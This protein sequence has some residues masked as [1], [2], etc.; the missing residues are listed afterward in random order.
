MRFLKNKKILTIIGIIL[1]I[2]VCFGIDFLI[3]NFTNDEVWTGESDIIEGD[4]D[5]EKS[6]ENSEGDSGIENDL[7]DDVSDSENLD[8]SSSSESSGNSEGSGES[9]N[10]KGENGE[11]SMSNDNTIYV[12]VTGEVN[13]QGVVILKEGSRITDAINAAGGITSNANITKINLV[14]ILEDGMKVNIPSNNQLKDNPDFEYITMGS[15]DGDVNSWTSASSNS[16]NSSGS[17]SGGSNSG[18]FANSK[19]SYSGQIQVIN[20]NTATQTELETLPGIGPSLALRI[21]N[22][23]EENGKFSSIEDIKN[24]SGIGDSRFEDIKNYITV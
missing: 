22:Y 6:G 13:N 7:T 19:N 15:G 1:L 21:I 24:V 14:F 11:S 18:G 23:R 4:L 12:Y 17:S 8:E 2:I 5:N 10:V 16:S 20:I 3:S 9:N